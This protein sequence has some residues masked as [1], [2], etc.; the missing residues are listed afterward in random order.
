MLPTCRSTYNDFS[1]FWGVPPMNVFPRIT[2]IWSA[3]FPEICGI[4]WTNH[5]PGGCAVYWSVGI[6]SNGMASKVMRLTQ[7][8]LPWV[9]TQFIYYLFWKPSNSHLKT[10]P[11]EKT[12][13]KRRNTLGCQDKCTAPNSTLEMSAP[14]PK[15]KRLPPPPASAPMKCMFEG[16]KYGLGIY[17]GGQTGH[18]YFQWTP[19]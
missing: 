2:L 14:I 18:W 10:R 4:H 16:V 12:D 9:L 19:Q 7:S 3:V 11:Q 6:V 17:S 15:R 5:R 8:I 13:V 1:R